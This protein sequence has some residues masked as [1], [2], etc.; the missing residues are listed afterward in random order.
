MMLLKSE[1]VFSYLGERRQP[2]LEAMTAVNFK[3]R[4]DSHANA[5]TTEEMS[6]IREALTILEEE[7]G[8]PA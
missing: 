4:K 1:N 3:G 2:I 6:D 8:Q 5:I 7:F